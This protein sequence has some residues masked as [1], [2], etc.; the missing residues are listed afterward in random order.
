MT[1]KNNHLDKHFFFHSGK[2]LEAKIV[3]GFNPEHVFS[4]LS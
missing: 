1:I 4:A 2:N 3:E